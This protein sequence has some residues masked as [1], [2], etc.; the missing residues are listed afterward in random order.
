MS[1]NNEMLEAILSVIVSKITEQVTSGLEVRLCAIEARLDTA[2]RKH[3]DLVDGLQKQITDAVEEALEEE[4]IDRKI[5]VALE[6]CDFI[7]ERTIERKI[8]DAIDEHNCDYDHDEFV[9]KDK[10][11]GEV[12]MFLGDLTFKLVTAE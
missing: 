4:N 10:M 6:D 12:K 11:E 3:D 9:E 1:N 8:S 5:E 2:E 7:D